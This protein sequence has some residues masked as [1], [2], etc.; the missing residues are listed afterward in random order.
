MTLVGDL[1]RRDIARTI[2]EVVKVDVDDDA[3]VA[4]EIDEYVVTDRIRTEFEEVVHEYVDCFDDRSD[5][6]NV[7]VSGFF[8][9]GK[10]SFA[11]IL[12]YLLENRVIAGKPVLDRFFERV[13]SPTLRA[14]LARALDPKNQGTAIT[15]LLDLSSAHDVEAEEHVIL[16]IY[17]AVL[18]RLGY[19]REPSLAALEFDLETDGRL[20]Q[21]VAA[22]QQVHGKPWSLVRHTT[23][24]PNMASRVLNQLDPDNFPSAD[25]WA[26]SYVAPTVDANWFTRRAVQLVERRGQGAR[27]L[28]IVVDETGQYVARSRK[29]MLDLQG[30]AEAVQKQ[31]GRIFLITTSQ[32]RLEEVVDSLEGKVVEIARVKDRFP[33]RVDLT[34]SDIRE[35]VGLRV[36][37]KNDQGRRTLEEILAPTRQRLAANLRL[38][39]ERRSS[40]F[41]TE[42]FVHLYPVVPYQIQLLIDSV[43]Q[44]R[45]Q[46]RAG[47]PLGGSNRTIIQHAQQLLA[48][49]RV[50]LA[51]AE[52]GTLVTLD[53]SYDL[54]IDVI[55]SALRH[56]ID[57]VID[58][59]GMHSTQ[60]QI[61]KVVALVHGVRSLPLTNHNLAVML[62]PSLQAEGRRPEVE[63]ATAGLVT[64]GWLRE[65]SEGFQLQSAEQ[66][67]WDEK[68]Q[69]DFRPGDEVRE[70]RRILKEELSGRLSVTHGRL[71]KIGLVVDGE[72]MAEG[73]VTVEMEA[74][75]PGREPAELVPATREKTAVSRIV[76]WFRQSDDTW[77]AL[78]EVFRS[79]TMVDRHSSASGSDLTRELVAEER[80]RQHRCEA[81]FLER[82]RADLDAGGLIFQGV[83]DAP[84]TGALTEALQSAVRD[85]LGEVYPHLGTFAARID[86]K[87]VLEIARTD[88]LS[89]LP[90]SLGDTGISLYTM[91]PE[92]PQLVTTHGPI[93]LIADEVRRRDDYGQLTTGVY[94]ERHFGA[95][96]YGAAP[97]VVQAAVA[98]ALRAGLVEL[99]YQGQRITSIS[100]RRLDSVFRGVAPFRTITVRLPTD[101]GPDLPTRSRLAERMTE[102]TGQ[103]CPVAL[104]ALASRGRLALHPHRE[105]VTA[106]VSFL[107]G[108]GLPVPTSVEAARRVLG[109]LDDDDAYL[110]AELSRD[111]DDL[112]AGIAAAQPLVDV[113]ADDPGLFFRARA[114][115]AL[116]DQELPQA[117]LVARDRLADLLSAGDLV[118]HLPLIR[119]TGADLEKAR[120]DH[121]R[122]ARAE[123]FAEFEQV[124]AALLAEGAGMEAAVVELSINARL[125]GLDPAGAGTV[126]QVLARRVRLAG[127]ANLARGE[128][129]AL[130]SAGQVVQLDVLAVIA[131]I[132]QGP[133]GSV[134]KLDAVLDG[135]RVRA[136]QILSEGKQVRLT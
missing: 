102:L 26:R 35:V 54:M 129:D 7:W 80:A 81:Q 32:E 28:V 37:D 17:R 117:C 112:L 45:S 23:L 5:R 20:D 18:Q 40:E 47:A 36:L 87:T 122:A 78:R 118:N 24:A 27:R 34:A 85:R 72:Q 52:V 71:F 130:R 43:T 119:S 15:T 128:L 106:V 14:L 53:R 67:Q 50:G 13:D 8:G 133:V 55:D 114:A 116:D 111:W 51:Q 61:M 41:S 29:R 91:T 19:A 127:A 121:L 82:L 31:Q 123:A 132:A 103:N 70:R 134:E 73:D 135:L 2:E 58:T 98:A 42:E 9:S 57:Q 83:D 101:T 94:L 64:A 4:A 39:S 44:R 12:G 110:V 136:I 93:R 69:L 126:E 68:R 22:F 30:L 113:M 56:Q 131:E 38:A 97:E 76:W 74:L 105:P 59:F 66:K 16:P 96:P 89:L 115:A 49:P 21:F 11:K 65:T 3:V 92:G 124:R 100:D 46:L 6:T 99:T 84:P 60:A 62:H 25:S 10:S 79:R 77:S 108:A 33:I 1:F 63:E 95:A 120:Q 75:D 104:E 107:T 48:N 109:A 88:D 125:S 90:A 86:P